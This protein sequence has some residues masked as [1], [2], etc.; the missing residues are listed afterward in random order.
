MA[1]VSLKDAA[2]EAQK[3]NSAPLIPLRELVKA[4]KT[5]SLATGK[6]E[7]KKDGKYGPEYWIRGTD[8]TLYI[9]PNTKATREQLEQATVGMN[10][11]VVYNGQVPTK[12]GKTFHDYEIFVRS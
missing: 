4:G 10:L 6:Y 12:N 11:E 5:G 7:G 3:E 2:K 1:D 9:V 8:D